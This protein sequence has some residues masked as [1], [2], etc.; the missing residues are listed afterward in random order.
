MSETALAA[1]AEIN[2]GVR[3]PREIASSDEVSFIPMSDVS[4]SGDWITQQTRQL[5]S[6][7]TGFTA[8]EEGDVLVAKI[9]PCLENGKGAHAQG[10]LRETLK[11]TS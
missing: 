1:I 6:V 10:L 9:T 5:R 8:F 4:E 11:K 3:I 7:T 2:P